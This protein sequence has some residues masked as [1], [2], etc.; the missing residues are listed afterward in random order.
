MNKNLL[1]IL[2]LIA[3]AIVLILVFT[4][5][6]NVEEEENEFGFI[7]PTEEMADGEEN[8]DEDEEEME[9]ADSEEGEEDEED[10]VD[11][12]FEI[13]GVNFAFDVTEMRVNEGDTVKVIFESTEGFH[14]W[15]VDEFDAATAQV[16][17]EDGVTEVT[18]V[19]DAA[20]EYEYYCSVGQHREQG[21]IG[22]LIVE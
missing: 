16:K 21:M 10:A 17:P 8:E 7:E 22:T 1:A 19:A 9:N 13:G 11:V 3:V 2:G 20:G 15:V 6:N 14:D 4:G 18:F 5:G 12:T